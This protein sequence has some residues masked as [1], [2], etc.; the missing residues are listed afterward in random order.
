M[1]DKSAE[2]EAEQGD[3]GSGNPES[4]DPVCTVRAQAGSVEAV[5]QQ[6]SERRRAVM[7]HLQP[8][9]ENPTACR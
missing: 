3:P 2:A 4:G 8:R 5:L 1:A 7:L 6:L 9:A